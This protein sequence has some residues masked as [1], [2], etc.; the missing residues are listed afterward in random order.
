M[1]IFRLLNMKISNLIIGIIDETDWI[2][3]SCFKTR[4]MPEWMCTFH[5]KFYPPQNVLTSEQHLFL[6][7]T[8]ENKTARIV[9]FIKIWF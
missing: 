8:Q 9:V 5:T 2:P 7:T 3:N 1:N 6:Q 4:I